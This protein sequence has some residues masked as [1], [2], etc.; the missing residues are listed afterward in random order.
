M[1]KAQADIIIHAEH[2]EMHMLFSKP[3]LRMARLTAS[4]APLILVASLHA[5]VA[6]EVI[7]TALK[8][9]A[10][11]QDLGVS[12]SV[13]DGAG[14]ERFDSAEEL[15]QRVAGLQAAVANGNQIAFQIRGIGAVDHQALTPTAAAVYVDGV[16]Q[17]TNVQTGP[18]L[19]DLE[20][21][22]VLKGPQG[23]LY[24]R[25]ASA[26][27]VNFISKRPSDESEGYVSSEIGNFDRFNLNAATNIPVSDNFALRLSGRYL[28]QGPQIDNVVTDETVSAPSEAGGERDEFGL[29]ALGLFSLE[30]TEVLLNVHYA[31]DNGINASPRNEGLDL[32]KHEISVGPSGV[33]DTDN[34]FYGASAE[35]AHRFDNG[36][37]FVSL[38]AFEGYHQQYGFDFAGLP[39]FFGGQNANLSYDRD[40]SQFSQE[41]RLSRSGSW[42]E[43]I[44]GLYLEAEEF[45]Q[46]YRVWCGELNLD[47]L[48]GSCNYIAANG[49]VGTDDRRYLRDT[50][51]ELILNDED[52][53]IIEFNAS[54]LQSLISQERQT[55][56]L[57]TYNQYEITPK[58]DFIWGARATFENIEGE[59]EGRHI[60]EDGVVGLNNQS[61]LGPATGQNEL[62]ESQVS[63]NIGLNYKLDDNRLL[64]IS[65]ANGYKSGGFNGEVISNAAHFDNAGLFGSET[66]DTV[67]IGAKLSGAAYRLNVAAFHNDYSDPQARFFD[68]FTLE[69]GE[70]ITLSSLSNFAAATS[71]GIDLDGEFFPFDGVRIYG[72]ATLQDSEIDDNDLV[73]EGEAYLDGDALPFASEVSYVV[74]INIAHDL[75]DDLAIDFNLSR[76]Y[77]S[78]FATGL[79]SVN[80]RSVSIDPAFI[81]QGYSTLDSDIALTFSN[82]YTV[83]LWGRN[84]GNSDYATSGYRFFGDTT[85]RGAP[86]SYGVSLK[87]SY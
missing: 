17:A 57:F 33:Q 43:S 11:A 22:E 21:A 67:E 47:T 19:F 78:E 23:S 84:L 9:S 39:S 15:S 87:Y 77:Q 75:T 28:T 44:V 42:Y 50:D 34:E 12:L 18:L 20:R 37:E 24:G 3:S 81:Q 82:Q 64:Y 76:K 1:A 40:F 60:F 53:P 69:S 72:A 80:T 38:T 41:L 54:T 31:E 68:S 14:L 29:R 2:K 59:G 26:G 48:V 27:A 8:S 35:I 5:Q 55:A 32:G 7:V 16:F 86:R 4:A 71:K 62:E 70:T 30:N 61:D 49:R 79:D 58:L 13:V 36:V 85:F 25:N 83:G 45:D 10:N 66:V 74:G 56:A 46:D 6:D 73:Y 52:D 51:G 63:G 65:Y